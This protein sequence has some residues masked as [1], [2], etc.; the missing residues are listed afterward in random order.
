MPLD[1]ALLKIRWGIT[2]PALDPLVE[3]VAGQA[4][5]LAETYS[6][7]RFDLMADAEDFPRV[8]YSFQVRRFPIQSI[9]AIW[10]WPDGQLPGDP[11]NGPN[12]GNYQVD[13]GKGLVWPGG[14]PAQWPG[15]MHCEYEG[16]FAEWPPDLSWAITLIA[17]LIWYDT[18][19]A[20]APAGGGGAAALGT[21][22]KLSVVGVYS[23]EF[24]ESAETGAAAADGNDTWGILTPPITSVLDRYR[25]AA[26]VGIG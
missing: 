17:D 7:R 6:G 25:L 18:P 14:A 9:T 19:G 22:R 16:G 13:K 5:A 23:A 1:P 8:T 4:Q 21:I 2:D 26:L 3:Q 12:I 20:G 10:L 15:V 11:P 24:G